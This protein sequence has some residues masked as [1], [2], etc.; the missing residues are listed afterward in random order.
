MPRLGIV[1]SET[2]TPSAR[3]RL[4]QT[5]SARVSSLQLLEY[6]GL[7]CS[8]GSAVAEA[9]QEIAVPGSLFKT[10]LI[11]KEKQIDRTSI[12]VNILLMD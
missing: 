6:P 4:P 10:S 2:Q 11:D 9:C 7:F 8:T 5:S 3:E 1:A 12:H